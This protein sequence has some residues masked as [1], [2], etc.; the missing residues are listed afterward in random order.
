MNKAKPFIKWAGGKRQLLPAILKRLP[1]SMNTFYEP[2]VG[3]GAVFFALKAKDAFQNAKVND[4]N[5]ELAVSY[6]V[7]SDPSN[8]AQVVELLKGYPHTR[9]FYDD[10]RTKLPLD[11]TPIAICARFI[12]LNRVGFN[13]LY[14]VNKG[15]GQF[16]VPFGK[17]VNPKICD[18]ANLTLVSEALSQ[19]KVTV[20]NLDF[21]KA[22]E[23]A[24]RGDVVYFDP[25]YIPLSPTSNFTEYQAGGFGLQEHTRLAACVKTLADRGVGV[26]LSNSDTSTTRKLYEGFDVELVQARRSINADAKK[27]GPVS[28]ILVAANLPLVAVSLLRVV[29]IR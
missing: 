5:R 15:K 21:E 22:V 3:G 9:E 26:L 19:D 2:F 8:L 29:R 14:R 23:G 28:E 10:L 16:N 4:L 6:Q 24:Q 27:R 12:Y 7:L 17:Y 25:P 1:A 18:E 11:L 13:G 20:S